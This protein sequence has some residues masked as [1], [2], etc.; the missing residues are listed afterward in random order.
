MALVRLLVN[1]AVYDGTEKGNSDFMF[2]PSIATGAISLIVSEHHKI[3][4][5][6]GIYAAGVRFEMVD[7]M[8]LFGVSPE[9][10]DTVIY[11]HLHE[12]HC[13]STA[14]FPNAD[15]LLGEH[16]LEHAKKNLAEEFVAFAVPEKRKI[17]VIHND[18]IYD[19]DVR[20]ICTPGHTPGHLSVIAK[21][22]KYGVVAVTGDAIGW[23]DY[24]L[25][26]KINPVNTNPE[27]YLSSI[28]KIASY[29]PDVL[30]IGHEP[31]ILKKESSA[32][33]QA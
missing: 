33:E 22:E 2:H 7:R 12:D 1:G 10:I 18:E 31:P 25:T 26:G 23:R 3:V 9:E 30:I 5:D 13:Q 16:E 15:I 21:D 8:K 20:I 11:T 4:V 6:T 17:V 24:Y 19:N 28:Q 27:R 32:H 14:V 29:E